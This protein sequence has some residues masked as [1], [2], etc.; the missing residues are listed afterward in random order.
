MQKQFART[1]LAAEAAARLDETRE[2]VRA[3]KFTIHGCAVSRRRHLFR[4][5]RSGARKAHRQVSDP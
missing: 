1:D 3:D 2:G 4:R 5:G